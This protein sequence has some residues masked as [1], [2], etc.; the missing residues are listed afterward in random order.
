VRQPPGSSPARHPPTLS[1]Q[2][3]EFLTPR[4]NGVYTQRRKIGYPAGDVQPEDEYCTVLMYVSRKESTV[5][6]NK[7][8][9]PEWHQ[10]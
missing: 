5:Q 8:R 6:N 3:D 1:A 10:T 9:V 7:K 2:Q 4:R